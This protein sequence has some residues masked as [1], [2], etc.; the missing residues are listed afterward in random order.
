MSRTEF[1]GKR[2]AVAGMGV[3]GLAVA[4]AVLDCGG[5][6]TVLDQQPG[7]IPRV[8]AAVDK[9]QEAGISAVTGWHGRLDAGDFDVLVVSPGIPPGHPV[10]LDMAG[11]VMGE[12]EFAYRVA[13]ASVLA[14]T[15]TN[16]KSTTTV[17][18]WLILSA[19]NSGAA[20]CGNIAGSGYPER[21]FTEAAMTTSSD[22][23]L[24]AEISSAQ[25]ETV[26]QFCP[27]VA[28]ITNIT[29]DHLDRYGTFEAY[30]DAKLNLLDKMGEGETVLLNLDNGTVTEEMI[31]SRSGVRIVEFSPSGAHVGNGVTRRDGDS[32]WF[33]GLRVD[34]EGLPFF[35][36]HN[37]I[38]A[39]AAW[40]MAACMTDLGEE[41][42]LGLLRFR[43][44][45]N[46]MELL[47]EKGGVTVINNSMCTNP[48]AVVASSR[49]VKQRQVLLMGGKTKNM[50]FSP[51]REYL[52]QNNHDVL[53]FGPEPE[54]INGMIGGSWPV[55]DRLEEAFFAAT[56]L[57]SS[58]E[59]IMLAPGC[60]SAEPFAN[61]KERG[62]AFR[63][64]AK[65]WLNDDQKTGP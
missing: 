17:M 46:R 51:V 62:N 10:M 9:L 56:Q 43:N 39:M 52:S 1:R 20:L 57:A 45:E 25:L 64:I 3:S 40:E 4:K 18:L 12:V 5:V 29:E 63:Q 58:G 37:L 6:P 48:E 53:I 22:G 15:G 55:Y 28:T 24:V 50:D 21:V 23:F 42:L 7:D 2:V 65:E 19:T 11:K 16:G 34:I 35:G 14:V 60:A 59:V 41:N 27:K 13:E 32:I 54:K 44:L 47:G 36:E 49:S 38:N 61:F 30:R 31:R 26:E 33:G 8:M